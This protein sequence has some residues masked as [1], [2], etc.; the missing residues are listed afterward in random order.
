MKLLI[1]KLHL[2]D[3]EFVTSE[4]IKTYCMPLNLD[5]KRAIQYLLKKGYLIRI[6]KGVYYRLSQIQ[7]PPFHRFLISNT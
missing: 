5:P 2:E 4:I 6:F 3:M 1:K 7:P